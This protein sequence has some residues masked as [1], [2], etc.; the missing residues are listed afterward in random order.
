PQAEVAHVRGLMPV[1]LDDAAGG[2]WQTGI[3]EESAHPVKSSRDDVWATSDAAKAM[4]ARMSS[5]LMRYSFWRVSKLS[6]PAKWFRMTVT[7]V[8]VPRITGLPWQMFGSM[9][10]RSFM[11]SPSPVILLLSAALQQRR[12]H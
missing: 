6:P 12:P 7:G 4:Q 3:D 1:R 2:A 10:M 11:A 9:T 5:A 8:R